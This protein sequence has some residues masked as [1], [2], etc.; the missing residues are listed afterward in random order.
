MPPAAAANSGP[1]SAT[2]TES[3][4]RFSRSRQRGSGQPI[5]SADCEMAADE[6]EPLEAIL[7]RALVKEQLGSRAKGAVAAK[8]AQV[9]VE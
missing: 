3:A 4:N 8:R 9:H 1:G 7:E 2:S 5:S 6:R